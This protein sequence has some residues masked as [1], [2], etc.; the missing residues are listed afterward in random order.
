MVSFA[1]GLYKVAM[2]CSSL[3]DDGPGD[4]LIIYQGPEEHFWPGVSS[5]G[6][7]TPWAL[8]NCVPCDCLQVRR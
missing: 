4:V 3:I 8:L 6:A 7:Q 2:Q 1:L 5:R